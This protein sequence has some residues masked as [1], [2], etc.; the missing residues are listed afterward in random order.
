MPSSA[1][2]IE[3]NRWRDGIVPLRAMCK[4][5]RIIPV[6][7]CTVS[8][9]FESF[10]PPGLRRGTGPQSPPRGKADGR[11]AISAP[12]DVGDDQS[13]A[14]AACSS[15]ARIASHSPSRMESRLSEP[16]SKQAASTANSA[17]VRATTIGAPGSCAASARA[18]ACRTALSS[19]G[20]KQRF[21]ARPTGRRCAHG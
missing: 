17:A 20:S 7:G 3:S 10:S 15:S 12:G 1:F 18:S 6:G 13:F 2:S 19:A 4:K 21:V 16:T 5:L 11:S 14:R 8:A 9:V